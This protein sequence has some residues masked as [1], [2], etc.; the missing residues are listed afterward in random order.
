MRIFLIHLACQNWKKRF[1]LSRLPCV[2]ELTR[3]PRSELQTE[4]PEKL[5]RRELRRSLPK[6]AK[7]EARLIL[8][9]Q[10]R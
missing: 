3:G 1:D 6:Q 10:R 7:M 9:L 4:K 5:E 8:K 2:A